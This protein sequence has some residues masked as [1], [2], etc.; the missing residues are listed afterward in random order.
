MIKKGKRRQKF[1]L[2][3]GAQGVGKTFYEFQL[4]DITVKIGKPVLCILGDDEEEAF[5]EVEE[6]E[7]DEDI[8]TEVLNTNEK[9][10]KGEELIEYK[11]NFKYLVN[12]FASH[13]SGIRK[14]YCD[15]PKLF[16][17]IRGKKKRGEKSLRGFTG[18]LVVL[19]DAKSF[20]TSRDEPLRRAI[21]RRRQKNNDYLLAVHGFSDFPPSLNTYLT[22]VVL[23]ETTD[24]FDDWN[25]TN[26]KWW[27]QIVERVNLKA[28]ANPHYKEEI[29]LRNTDI[30]E[31]QQN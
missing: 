9:K 8:L 21:M 31:Y 5:W 29:K 10:I 18:G 11:E 25:I 26:K 16:D 19:D 27:K 3:S 6:L 2:L 14:V 23:W 12:C 20:I 13:T 1:I 24:D 30:L 4:I 22:D 15:N 17:I 28:K 7:I